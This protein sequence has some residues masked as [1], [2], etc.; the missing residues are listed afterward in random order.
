M[1]RKY[2]RRAKKARRK[3]GKRLGRPRGSG[4]GASA[5][6]LLRQ[7]TAYRRELEQKRLSLQ[8]ELDGV[9]S[10]ISAMGGTAGRSGG[11]GVRGGRRARRGAMKGYILDVMK[12]GQEMTV[13]E[14]SEA[15]RKAGYKT[16]SKNF[17]NQV[18]NTLAKMPE[19]YKVGR[20]LFRVR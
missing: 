16:K 4:A 1:A 3:S 7:L 6:G 14:I 11:A 10:A 9:D 15:I 13:K 12:G 17:G 19:L 2:K 5:T 20:G 8:Q 18:S